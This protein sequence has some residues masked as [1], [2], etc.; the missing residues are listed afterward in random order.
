MA[1]NGSG[2]F[3]R[4]YNWVTDR[5]NGIKIRADRMDAEMDGFATGL[6]NAICKDGQTTISNDIPF[7]NH[8]ITG[9]A[10]ATADT[11]AMN[12]QTGDARYMQ[13]PS[14]LAAVTDLADGD[15]FGVYDLSATADKGVTYAALKS[16]L[17]TEGVVFSTGAATVFYNVTAPT[18]WTK[19]T[20]AALNDAAIRTVTDTSGTITGGSDGFTTAFASRTLTQANLPNVTFSD[21][22]AVSVTNGTNVAR[23]AVTALRGASTDSST[24][25]SVTTSDITASI[26]GSVTSGGSGTALSFAVKYANMI[27]A[28]KD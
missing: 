10:D 18:G 23:S 26:T 14:G 1:F 28:T 9:L 13:R 17:R 8:K 19:N 21:T 16:Y 12:R 4:L 5:S 24:V 27:H 20:T 25:A 22:F 11:H 6:S 2:T 3:S 7:N 15:I